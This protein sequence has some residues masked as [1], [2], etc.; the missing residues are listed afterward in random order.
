M[1]NACTVKYLTAPAFADQEINKIA[2]C[3][4]QGKSDGA[5]IIW[6]GGLK[7]DMEGSKALA[8]HD[9]AKAQDR[10]YVRFDY[11]GHGKSTGRF[12]DGTVS[13]WAQDT[14]HVIDELTSGDQIIVGS[15]MG[16][17][18]ALLA[19]L[20]RPERVK[21]L[22]LIAPAPDFTEKLMWAR[23]DDTIRK[24]IMED[25]IYYEP[26]DYDEPYEISRELIVDGRENQLL[27]APISFNGPVRIL[28]GMQDTSVPWAH[29]QKLLDVVTSNDM[30]MT[31]VK[32][33]DHS[34]SRES[35]IERLLKTVS[36]LNF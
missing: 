18:T 9:W 4:N 1:T 10:S 30:E 33:G 23:F 6:C 20:A 14:V 16:G 17:W 21:A 19:A 22:V 26:S 29:A 8:L 34:L 11:F 36:L 15:S 28:Q 2:Y 27:D 13:R 35:D 24:T 3:K 25:G 12:R 32:D 5:G 31:L 7:S